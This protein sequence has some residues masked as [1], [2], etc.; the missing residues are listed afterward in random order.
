MWLRNVLLCCFWN[1]LT[2]GRMI[3]SN[4]FRDSR[5]RIMY[6]WWMTAW[7]HDGFLLICACSLCRHLQTLFSAKIS[8]AA[9]TR[10][11]RLFYFL[12]FSF[13]YTPSC[14]ITQGSLARHLK[15]GYQKVWT[16]ALPECLVGVRGLI[17]ADLGLNTNKYGIIVRLRPL[18]LTSRPCIHRI[19]RWL[20]SRWTDDVM[21]IHRLTWPCP[22]DFFIQ[23]H[24]S[25]M[26]EK[27]KWRSGCA[28]G[29]SASSRWGFSSSSSSED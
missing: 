2:I 20:T 13:Y 11:D 9:L 25:P 4:A 7:S 18:E 12:T 19:I 8:G 16:T 26:N 3:A 15:S 6:N 14:R 1:M 28:I 5:H 24:P 27:I 23:M 21:I 17:S 10:I 22:F 29:I